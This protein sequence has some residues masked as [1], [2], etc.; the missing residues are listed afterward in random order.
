MGRYQPLYIKGMAAGLTQEREEF[1][2]PNDAYPVLLN[3]FV[4]RERIKRKKGVQTIGRLQR[5]IAAF[6]IGNWSGANP[7][8]YAN[9]LFTLAGIVD[10]GATISPG[11]I[12]ITTL[13]G[14][15][16]QDFNL[17]GRLISTFGGGYVEPITGVTTGN[18]TILNVAGG[19]FNPGDIVYITGIVGTEELNNKYWTVISQGG[20]TLTINA[21]SSQQYI[22]GG[23]LQMSPGS[24]DYVDGSI[25]MRVNVNFLASAI[26]AAFAY[27][28]NLP[29]MGIL[30]REINNENKEQTVFFDQK[31]AY[32][33]NGTTFQEFIPGFTW[34]GTDFNFFW[35]TNYWVTPANNK[36][37]WVTNFSDVGG[38]PIRYSA[39]DEDPT[40]WID[41]APTINAAGDKLNQCLAMLPFRGRL[42]AFRTFEGPNL[43]GSQEKFQRIRWASIGNPISD[44][45]VLFPLAANV[46]A[47]AWRDDI[48]GRGGFLD[49][50]TA[51][52][53]MAVGFVRDNCV[54]YC[55]RSTWQLRYTGRSIAPFQIERVNSEL[56]A[57]STFSAVQFDTSLVGIGDKGIVQCDSFKSERIDIKIPD[58]VFD[59]HNIENG[60]KRVYGIRDFQQRLAYWI[61]PANWDTNDLNQVDSLIKYPNHRLVYNYENDSWAVFQDSFTALGNLQIQ[62]EETWAAANYTWS[63][64]DFPWINK[65]SFFPFIAA[66]NQQGYIFILDQYTYNEESLFISDITG[67]DPNVTVIT[68][69]SHNLATGQIIKIINIAT[70]SNYANLSNGIFGVNVLTVDTFEIYKYNPVNGQFDDPQ[71]NVAGNFG[72]AGQ[73]IVRDN[74]YIQSKKFNF[75][76]SG[77]NIQLGYIDILMDSTT[78]GAITMNVYADYNV[79]NPMNTLPNNI[80][81]T[82]GLPDTFF[83]SVIP[84]SVPV[85]R[86][87]IKN[88]QRVFCPTRA[89]FLT[90][91]F[92]LSNA[93]MNDIEQESDVQIDTQIM[94]IRPAG[95]QLPIGV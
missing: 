61:Y 9:N 82:T 76:D 62:N 16:F 77:E 59:F 86:G 7:D 57:E 66:G 36:L 88:W 41:F 95:K 49:I 87:S 24:V 92:T 13:F 15:T 20:G 39:F 19:P 69:P 85:D 75:L 58:L 6:G 72:G 27:N 31:Y 91:E 79:A 56:G 78:S 32:I 12:T 18:P 73:I 44:T 8:I 10:V 46:N 21:F 2:L 52:S 34:T 83:N 25:G 17:D 26:T 14:H 3:A 28:P 94:W 38:D 67:N 29:V 50:P 40:V 80:N 1:I 33:Y 30:S 35:G 51:E 22:S 89:A 64:A 68:S 45:S 60:N 65:P 55:E 81:D 54:I 47:T 23:L 11:S 74:F 71:V 84:T 93:Q 53:I 43:A 37:F 90:T 48:R 63:S 5:L 70:T 42:V 4:W